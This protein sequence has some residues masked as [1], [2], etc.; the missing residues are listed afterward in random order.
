MSKLLS[1]P[2]KA[3]D[4]SRVKSRRQLFTGPP[5]FHQHPDSATLDE[6]LSN[7][8]GQRAIVFLD[9]FNDLMEKCPYLEGELLDFW[10]SGIHVDMVTEEIIDT[11]KIIWIL[12]TKLGKEKVMRAFEHDLECQHGRPLR[13]LQD[14][15]MDKAII[16]WG[17]SL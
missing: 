16:F 10:Q 15:L 11:S 5:K 1:V 7:V 4:C 9:D 2:F 12:N 3:V 8:A 13:L 6:F 17:A 14:A